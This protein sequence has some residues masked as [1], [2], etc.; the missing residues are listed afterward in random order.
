MKKILFIL[1]LVNLIFAGG[2]SDSLKLTKALK[3]ARAYVDSGTTT[4]TLLFSGT[5]KQVK[6]SGIYINNLDLTKNG[7]IRLINGSAELDTTIGGSSDHNLLNNLHGDFPY[8]HL[9]LNT[10]NYLSTLTDTVQKQLNNKQPL[11]ATL[12][13]LATL[14]GSTG[15]LYQTAADAFAKYGFAGTGSNNTVARSDHNHAD[16]YEPILGV[17]T[18]SQ[19]YR[20]DKSWQILN[21]TAVPEGTGLYFTTY[22]ARS[23][24]S[25]SGLS[26]SVAT[27]LITHDQSPI[28]AGTYRSLTVNNYGHAIAGTNPTTLAGYG[29]TDAIDGA[30]TAGALPIWTDANTLSN[31]LLSSNG[32]SMLL[33]PNVTASNYNDGLRIARSTAG[34]SVLS[35]GVAANSYSGT[36]AGQWN[37]YAGTTAMGYDFIGDCNGIVFLRITPSGNMAIGKS[38]A[39]VEAWESSYRALQ[40]GGNTSII[41]YAAEGMG[42]PSLYL[43][44]C[45]FDGSWKPQVSGS[46]S[47][48]NNYSSSHLWYIDGGLTADVAYNPTIIMALTAGNLTLGGS[49]PN[50][51]TATPFLIDLTSSHSDG[52]TYDKLKLALYH[53]GAAYMGFGIGGAADIQYH[54]SYGTG[55]HD[56]YLN[57]VNKFS[58][59]PTGLNSPA[60]CYGNFNMI[61]GQSGADVT[62]LKSALQIIQPTINTDAFMSFHITGD[63]AVYFGLD[64]TTNDL[65]VGGWSLGAVKN[66]IWHAGNDGTGSG[67]DAD[68][69]DGYHASSF[70]RLSGLTTNYFTKW[71]GTTLVNSII[72]DNGTTAQIHLS[73][74][75]GISFSGDNGNINRIIS[76]TT[77]NSMLVLQTQGAFVEMYGTNPVDKIIVAGNVRLSDNLNVDKWMMGHTPSGSLSLGSGADTNNLVVNLNNY[78]TPLPRPSTIELDCVSVQNDPPLAIGTYFGTITTSNLNTGLYLVNYC[79]SIDY[80]NTPGIVSVRLTAGSS[81]KGCSTAGI[82]GVDDPKNLTGTALMYINT[83]TECYIEM[84]ADNNIPIYIKNIS[85]SFIKVS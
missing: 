61:A 45:Y 2:M 27:G 53:N 36:Q 52:F 43:N 9:G 62:G 67:L 21:T 85:M 14:D 33:T 78:W 71:D 12:T 40:I 83:N 23:S 48:Y 39:T 49:M 1:L 68:L 38:A 59:I 66:K 3:T 4:N 26:Y 25:V 77:A 6:S 82:W 35:L 84:K 41:S 19:Y 76:N 55:T 58:V 31:S 24:I 10:Y 64:G 56:F 79:I 28:T 16:I 47:I 18:T 22:R 57:N 44:N 5:N 80:Y 42:L 63:Y 70:A 29:I 60:G 37:Y 34:Y 50:A 73:G 75:D 72:S 51:Q 30:G 32:I 8:Y 15:F 7:L 17:G 69:L 81:H 65:F 46:A 13:T 74:G 54:N 11:D 20:G